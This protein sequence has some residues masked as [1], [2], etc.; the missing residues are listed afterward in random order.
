MSALRLILTSSY[1]VKAAALGCMFSCGGEECLEY[2]GAVP[3]GYSSIED[4]Y[5]KESGNLRC[6][7]AQT[8]TTAAGTTAINLKRNSNTPAAEIGVREA[9][10]LTVSDT[11]KA[12]I[13]GSSLYYYPE[14]GMAFARVAV[15]LVTDLAKGSVREVAKVTSRHPAFL[16]ALAATGP[17]L[18]NGYIDTDGG[19]CIRAHEA[20]T[21]GTT[22]RLTGWWVVAA[23]NK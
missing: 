19:L 14:E 16:H 5:A 8:Y 23:D 22:L 15:T 20:I 11:S 7:S 17:K 21:A 10:T 18:A 12:T 4:W 2:T 13:D 1:V 9:L 3:A 6:W